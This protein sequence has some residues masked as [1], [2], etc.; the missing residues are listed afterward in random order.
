MRTKLV[1]T[2]VVLQMEAAE[3]GAASLAIML[4][5][6]GRI[7]PLA[8]LRV[9]CGV[10][11]DGSNAFN[12]IKAAERYGLQAAGYSRDIEGLLDVEPPYVVFWNFN[13]FLV[14]EG[15]RRGHVHLNDPAAGHVKISL[16]EFDKAFTGVVLTFEP[17]ERFERGGRAP[18]AIRALR[19]RARGLA[20]PLSFAVLA[21]FL[22]VL[23]G[24]AIPA[25]S[26]VFIDEILVRGRSDWMRPLA[27]L[28]LAT[29][30]AVGL[31]RILQFSGLRRMRLALSARLSSQFFW[32]LLHLPVNFY[33]QRY[34]GEISNRGRMNERVAG[35]LSGQLAQTVI[36]VVMMVFYAAVMWVYNPTLTGVAVASAL[37]NFLALRWLGQ[38]RVEANMRLLQEDGKVAGASIAA[39]QSM[40]TIKASG[41]E[42]GFFERW[43]G[44]YA[45]ASN[46]RQQ[47]ELSNQVLGV[48]PG[49]LAA[50]TNVLVLVLGGW[51]VIEGQVTF[52]A[53]F[54]IGKLI[55][56]QL[57]T[58]SFLRPVGNLVRLG[59]TLQELRG[60]LMR[61]EDVLSYERDP[62]LQLRAEVQAPS[63]PPDQAASLRL[64][65]QLELRKLT[66]GYDRN[67]PPLIEDFDLVLRPGKRVALVG[68]SGSGKSTLSKLICGLYL[69][70]SGEILFDGRP[71]EEIPRPILTSA[72]AMVDQDVLLFAGSV[73]QN[74]TLWDDT[75]P[76]RLLVAACRDAEILER[77]RA[78]PGGLDGELD[79][80]GGNLSGGERQRL[81]IARALVTQPAIL[82]LDEATSALD[83]ESE[84]LIVERIALRGCSCVI[85]AHRL[86]TIRDCDEIIV[87]DHGK[88]V[89]RG[90]HQEL[91]RLGGA[92]HA[93]LQSDDASAG[94]AAA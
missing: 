86:S 1:R 79:E 12:M 60:D 92:Y 5:H 37:F 27:L 9:E 70:W 6:Y 81:E 17:T 11:R 26:Q 68:G 38:R 90:T 73:R 14:V 63:A 57:L 8:E 31:L 59:Q 21:G 61:L 20:G 41:L 18:S 45:N 13:H 82:V 48:L 65:G 30:G 51:H 87:L 24:L 40:E 75:V 46:A 15:M 76:E 50:G 77:V 42:S 23:P 52:A 94:E 35:V 58:A 53:P 32:H 3:C 22:L 85:V 19:A 44:H 74:L 66:F 91:W 33:A 25:F 64:S 39:L 4:A 43:S 72:L 36:D 80:G 7:V 67:A 28:M 47:L 83:T 78:L 88:V 89:E 71:R 16:E 84:R 93:L 56:F 10:T 55:A 62:A 2:P 34:A 29:A 69:P 54:T 49:L